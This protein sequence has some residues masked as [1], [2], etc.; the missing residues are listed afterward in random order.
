MQ[1]VLV[2]LW[3][4]KLR[5]LTDQIIYVWNKKGLHHPVAKIKWLENWNLWQKVTSF[6]LII[7]CWSMPNALSFSSVQ[8][9]LGIYDNYSLAVWAFFCI[10]FVHFFRIFFL[11][12]FE[13]FFSFCVI[14]ATER[15]NC[16]NSIRLK[17][18]S[19]LLLK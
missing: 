17:V 6:I 2:D 13:H 11:T 15:R 16:Q 14:F 3:H 12:E 7:S 10:F 4:F 9:F 5:I 8:F 18:E 19:S 1:P